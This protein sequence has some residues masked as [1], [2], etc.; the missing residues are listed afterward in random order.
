MEGAPSPAGIAGTRG[1]NLELGCHDGYWNL[2]DYGPARPKSTS[3]RL[4]KLLMV[5]QPHAH[6]TIGL[7]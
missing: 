7:S 2:Y 5:G 3:K 6:G 4:P 1:R